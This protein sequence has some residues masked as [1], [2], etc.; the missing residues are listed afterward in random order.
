MLH[1]PPESVCVCACVCGGGEASLFWGGLQ[2]ANPTG[3]TDA[4]IFHD[5]TGLEL[6]DETYP[7][8][9]HVRILLEALNLKYKEN[10]FYTNRCLNIQRKSKSS[11]FLHKYYIF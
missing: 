1:P 10:L 8:S 3:R 11:S 7:I 2:G 4:L 5:K 9:V 6:S